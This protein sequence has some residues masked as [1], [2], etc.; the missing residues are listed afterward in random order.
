[1]EDLIKYRWTYARLAI[2]AL[3]WFYII[4]FLPSERETIVSPEDEPM[5][6]IGAMVLIEDQG[7][8][9]LE[10]YYTWCKDCDPKRF[11]APVS[12]D[13]GQIRS[14]RFEDYTNCPSFIVPEGVTFLMWDGVQWFSSDGHLPIGAYHVCYAEFAFPEPIDPP[15]PERS[16]S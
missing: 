6:A 1:M 7:D 16:T 2:G 8:A 5:Q 10:N 12:E 9:V 13:N 3:L 11:V 4:I 15:S 14:G